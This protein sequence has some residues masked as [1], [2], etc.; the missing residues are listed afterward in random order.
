MP[1]LGE[2]DWVNDGRVV[3]GNGSLRASRW[4][5]CCPCWRHSFYLAL[6]RFGAGFRLRLRLQV[7]SLLLEE[8]AAVVG[9]VW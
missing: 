5:I 2:E 6:G 3:Q 8:W 4:A 1:A 9:R 7:S